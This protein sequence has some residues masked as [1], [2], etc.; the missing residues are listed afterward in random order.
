MKRGRLRFL[1]GLLLLLAAY[2]RT[3]TKAK[4]DQPPQISVIYPREGAQIGA[5]DSTFIFGSVT[6]KSRL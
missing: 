3:E 5:S 1:F 6:P 4:D 2:P